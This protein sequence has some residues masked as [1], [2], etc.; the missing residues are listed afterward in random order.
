MKVLGLEPGELLAPATHERGLLGLA[1][2]AR[3]ERILEGHPARGEE[4]RV[5]PARLRQRLV[6]FAVAVA[7]KAFER[8][9]HGRISIAERLCTTPRGIAAGGR[10]AGFVPERLGVGP[11]GFRRA[12]REP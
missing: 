11:I 8:P 5:A 1:G 6:R 7:G 3:V 12:R 9:V 4:A 2:G 10:A